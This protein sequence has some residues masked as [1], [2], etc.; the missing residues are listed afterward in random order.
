MG[1][2]TALAQHLHIRIC[3]ECKFSE[4]IRTRGLQAAVSGRTLRAGGLRD[5]SV[6]ESAGGNE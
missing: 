3:E 6:K 5:W 2:S 4:E 1:H